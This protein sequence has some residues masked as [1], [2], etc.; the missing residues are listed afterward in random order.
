MTRCM[1][2]PHVD[3]IRN[4]DNDIS[5]CKKHIR[6]FLY[7]FC[8]MGAHSKYNKNSRNAAF[9][10]M[11]TNL[12]IQESQ[13]TLNPSLFQFDAD[14]GLFRIK[15]VLE[16]MDDF[17]WVILL[18]LFTYS[19]GGFFQPTPFLPPSLPQRSVAFNEYR[20]RLPEFTRYGNVVAWGFIPEVVFAD[21]EQF[22]GRLMTVAEI[23][24]SAKDYGRLD[25][26]EM[27][28]IKGRAMGQRMEQSFKEYHFEYE[29]WISIKFNPLDLEAQAAFDGQFREYK[30]FCDTFERK[31]AT[32]YIKAFDECRNFEEAIKLIE[33]TGPLLQRPLIFDEILPQMDSVMDLY[34]RD[35]EFAEREFRRGIDGYKEEGLPGIPFCKASFPAVTGTLMWIKALKGHVSDSIKDLDMLDFP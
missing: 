23:L 35:I 29:K 18:I 15:S 25:K 1:Q 4:N 31:L 30:L 24:N 13:R 27:G 2:A 22:R 21:F 6:P 32:T 7:C 34:V 33:M 28:G 5:K 20:E 16:V 19:G 11:I 12:L 3:R 26:M 10:R 9:I 14:E 17:R 8:L